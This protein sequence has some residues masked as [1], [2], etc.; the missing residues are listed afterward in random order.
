MPTE[1]SPH[2]AV[3]HWQECSGVYDFLEQVRLRPGMWLPGGSLQHL[4]SILT[5]YRVALAV[6]SAHEPFGF[7]PE[8][9]FI[10]WLHKHYG[11]SSSLTWAAEI[12]RH[13]PAGS[14]AVDEF[15]RLLE[16]FRRDA[17]QKPAL[18]DPADRLPG[19]EYMTNTFVTLFWR[20]RLL[21]QAVQRLEDRDF[22]VVH[23]AARGWTT[24]RDM[25]QAVAAALQFPAY[26]GHNLDALNDCL[27]DVACFG[28][29]DDNVAE[30]AGLVLS[31]TDYDR[32]A[33]AAPRA[34]Q[35]VL[36]IVADQA[37]R[38]AIVR[39]RFFALVHSNDSDI[40]FEPVG[41][42]PVMWNSDEWADSNR[43]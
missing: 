10:N 41:A 31:L 3:K 29:Y 36:D 15:F 32:F 22:R 40:R 27:G 4:Q 28:P 24:E 7:W 16:H 2:N 30:G 5:G 38:A 20:R 39:R 12:E 18:Q 37:R 9:D 25:H 23:L 35:I 43:R 21:T 11:I 8:E 34:A 26:Y 17:P 42:M 1:E 33:A 13:T 19:I 14:T 6:H